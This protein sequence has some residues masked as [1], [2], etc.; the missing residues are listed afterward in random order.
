MN[1]TEEEK[2]VTRSF[3]TLEGE[4]G[5]TVKIKT[6]TLEEMLRGLMNT[7]GY[8]SGIKNVSPREKEVL[9]MLEAEEIV[10][11][12]HS[13][14]W[15]ENKPERINELWES[16]VESLGYEDSASNVR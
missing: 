14:G 3:T 9:E 2:E 11:L 4:D 5:K 16:V 7:D 10:G 13:A 1:I 8:V 6:T 12:T 15:F